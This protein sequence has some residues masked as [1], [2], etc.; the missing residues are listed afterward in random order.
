MSISASVNAETAGT[1]TPEQRR[2][3]AREAI[4]KAA[5]VALARDGY[6]K[7]TTRRIAKIA[8]VN[9]ATL[10][11]YFG[12]KES[13]LSEVTRF[14][15]KDTEEQ[16]RRAM[17][18]ATSARTAMERVFTTIL[19]LVKDRPGIL[20]YDLI[21]RGFRDEAA[22]SEA[23]AIYESYRTLTEELIDWNLRE[24]GA[25]APGLTVSGL[26]HYMLAAVDGVLL[27]HV[28]TED[29]AAAE[30]ALGIIAR[31]SLALLNIAS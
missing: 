25:L 24:G 15:L 29:D 30:R 9:I 7:I 5:W 17:E 21:V 28:L 13:L 16:L 4:L 20:R 27:Q 14:A 22:R 1:A 31:H 10:H 6:E 12:T 19:E 8:G 23:I 18:E 2:E 26:A 3:Q 11:Y